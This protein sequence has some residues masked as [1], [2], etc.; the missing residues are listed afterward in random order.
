MGVPHKILLG[1]LNFGRGGPKDP[2]IDVDLHINKFTEIHL[3]W[4]TV[5]ITRKKINVLYKLCKKKNKK[6]T[7]KFRIYLEPTHKQVY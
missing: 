1:P 4:K 3:N 2:P 6:K 7:H 5:S